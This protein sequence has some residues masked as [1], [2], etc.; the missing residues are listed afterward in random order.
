[1]RTDAEA[2]RER[3]P[4]TTLDSTYLLR[5]PWRDV[6]RD[7]V[8][9]HSGREIDYSYVETPEAVF[10]VPLLD[11]GRIVL[12]R[13]YRYPVRDWAW[14]V[15]AGSIPSGGDARAAEET[16]CSELAEEVG[17]TCRELVHL[18]WF[19]S[20][21]AHLSLRSHAFLALG[22]EL[23][24][25]R[26]EPTELLEVVPLDVEDALARARTGEINEGQSALAILKAEPRIRAYLAGRQRA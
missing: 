6:R 23:G 25:A 17:G 22:V 4:W 24:D 21:S 26:R 2:M 19:Y 12:I 7:R 5:S 9:L 16:A 3:A 8:R 15:P 13:Q 18:G 14:E 11:D 20:S 1:V 10:V